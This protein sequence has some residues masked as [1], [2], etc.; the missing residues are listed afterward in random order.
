MISGALA[1]LGADLV[2]GGLTL[3]TG[4]LVGAEL[5]AVGAAEL[6]KG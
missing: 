5:G 2:A 4:A 6:A 1:R 3:G